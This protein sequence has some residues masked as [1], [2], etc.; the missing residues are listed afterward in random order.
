MQEVAKENDLKVS[1]YALRW[2]SILISYASDN[3]KVFND[4]LTGYLLSLEKIRRTN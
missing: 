4:S 1:P 2:G 3:A